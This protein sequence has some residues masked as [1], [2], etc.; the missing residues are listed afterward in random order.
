LDFTFG[1][2]R[3]GKFQYVVQLLDTETS[4]VFYEKL[5][6]VYLEMHN[7]NKTEDGLET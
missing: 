1:K 5:T 6:F 3:E 2:E 4:E 7:F